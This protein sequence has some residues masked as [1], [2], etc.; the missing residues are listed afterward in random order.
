MPTAKEAIEISKILQLAKSGANNKYM[1]STQ[2]FLAML[3]DVNI[4]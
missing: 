3:T 4:N 2:T 1:G